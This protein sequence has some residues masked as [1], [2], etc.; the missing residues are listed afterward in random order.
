MPIFHLFIILLIVLIWGSNFIFI[1]FALKEIS[2]LLLCAVRFFLAS[3]P[4]ILFF[5]PPKGQFRIIALYGLITFGL[6]FSLLFF[7]MYAGMT[8]GLAS[9]LLQVQIFFSI[10][11]A[12]V[13]LG[14]NP[15]IWQVVGAIV[16]FIGIGLIARHFDQHISVLGFVLIIAAAAAWGAGNLLTKKMHNM[17]MISLVTWGSFF[18][19]IPIFILSLIVEGPKAI[20]TSFHH[21]T[22]VGI[23][24]VSYIVYLS[25]WVGYGL[26]NWLVAR[27]RVAS[28]AP[29]T[30]L[31]PIVAVISSALVLGEKMQVWKITACALILA[32]LCINLFGGKL[33]MFLPKLR[34]RVS[35]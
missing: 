16:S 20:T 21:L 26:W 14:E 8:P 15:H 30:L 1:D 28:I 18:A 11:F 29:F 17:N 19:C 23:L 5:K 33:M 35:S 6:Q 27:H 2:P 12:V 25:T 22:H 3:F 24:S 31:V 32:G 7:G 10:I 34:A 4:A 9:I 13:F